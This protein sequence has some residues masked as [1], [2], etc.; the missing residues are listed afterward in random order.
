MECVKDRFFKKGLAGHLHRLVYE[1]SSDLV[2]R[3]VLSNEFPYEDL[4]SP[5]AIRREG[6]VGVELL[7]LAEND[8][9]VSHTLLRMA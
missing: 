8:S 1:R 4:H 2:V 5:V 6:Q 9:D 3:N 7:R